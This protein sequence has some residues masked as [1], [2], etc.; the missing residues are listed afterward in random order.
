MSHQ[1]HACTLWNVHRY[2]TLSGKTARIA[3]S[4]ECSQS[5]MNLSVIH[6]CFFTPSVKN[7]ILFRWGYIIGLFWIVFFHFSVLCGWTEVEDI[8]GISLSS[9]AQPK[10]NLHVNNLSYFYLFKTYT[11]CPKHSV[12]LTLNSVCISSW[13]LQVSRH[14]L[15]LCASA[16]AGSLLG[17]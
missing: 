8:G 9:T 4:S 2:T 3:F 1:S 17:T 14:A 16:C 11:V 6:A 5:I 15:G 10:V 7:I 12:P 13:T